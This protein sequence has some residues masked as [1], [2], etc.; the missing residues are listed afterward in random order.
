MI[1]ETEIIKTLTCLI[2]GEFPNFEIE[3]RDIEEGFARP[4]FFIEITDVESSKIGEMYSDG[5]EIKIYFFAESRKSGYLELLKIKKVLR[6]LLMDNIPL[7]DNE[8]FIFGF[9]NI[10]FNI[11]KKDKVLIVEANILL[12]QDDDR[13]D[14]TPELEELEFNLIFGEGK[15]SLEGDAEDGVSDEEEND[16][17]CSIKEYKEG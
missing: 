4:S 3:D 14:D 9:D 15:I 12:V 5:Q 6:Y 11:N 10:N 17:V 7:V 8:E 16:F 2:R 13:P 1:S